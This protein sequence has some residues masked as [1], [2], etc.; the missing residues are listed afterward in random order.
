MEF[1]AQNEPGVRSLAVWATPYGGVALALILGL[2][3]GLERG[4]STREKRDG[5]RVAGMRTFGLLGLAGGMAGVISAYSLVSFFIIGASALILIVGYFRSSRQDA[6]SLSATTTIV[7]IITLATGYL[8]ATSNGPLACAIAAV[9]VVV[10]SSR[11]QLH[12]F[13]KDL[14]ET[15]IR[16]VA[17]F[18]LIS[19][20]V[21]PM[22]PDESFGP[23]GAWNP[24]EIW[25]VVV[26]VC[27]LSFSGY[28]ANRLWGQSRGTLIT[29]ALGSIVSS[30]AVSAALAHK[31][32]DRKDADNSITAGIALSS[33]VMLL[34]VLIL[35]FA[36]VPFAFQALAM[37]IGPAAFM[38][39]VY[40]AFLLLRKKP[41][42][43]GEQDFKL[44]N[45][46]EFGPALLLAVLVAVTMVVVR[47]ML[48]HYGN[49]G[50]AF[51]FAISGMLDIDSAIIAMHGLPDGIITGKVAGLALAGPTLLNSLLK[52]GLILAIAG[53]SRGWRASLPIIA[54]AATGLAAFVAMGWF[55]SST[56]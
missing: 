33:T 52:V 55:G 27:G 41:G 11:N 10:L 38:S 53:L 37:I 43:D 19:L 8:A 17:R 29:A 1:L 40:A 42:A 46:F 39:A 36:L 18:A 5:T 15:E 21:L 16:A 26:I 31:L 45:P 32:R 12:A 35:S 50:V 28:V 24:R 7:G 54:G 25:G 22:L 48:D 30:T 49:A 9:V 56:L 6:D 23:Y 3:I 44:K 14:N 13:V 51:T 20:A 34:R 4:W 47:W 2:L